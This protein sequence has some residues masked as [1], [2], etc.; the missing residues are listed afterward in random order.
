[1]ENTKI[2]SKKIMMRILQTQ[3]QFIKSKKNSTIFQLNLLLEVGAMIV[4]EN[5]QGF[6]KL[7]S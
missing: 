6:I 4:K 7:W 5:S 3:K 1:M 2:G